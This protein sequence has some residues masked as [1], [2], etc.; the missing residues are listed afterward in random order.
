MHFCGSQKFVPKHCDSTGD[1][2]SKR[3]TQS[4]SLLLRPPS[5][6]TVVVSLML[7]VAVSRLGSEDLLGWEALAG[8]SRSLRA[9][10]L[11]RFVVWFGGQL[12]LNVGSVKTQRPVPSLW[13]V[14]GV[15]MFSLMFILPSYLLARAQYSWNFLSMKRQSASSQI[16]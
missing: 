5:S 3:E 11:R 15:N 7:A 14:P 13:P 16:I 4:F 12:S 10:L 2:I 1:E 8:T 6:F 9:I